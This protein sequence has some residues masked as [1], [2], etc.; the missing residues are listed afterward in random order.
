MHFFRAFNLT[1]KH[2]N[3]DLDE[4]CRSSG[5][6]SKKLVVFCGGFDTNITT[7]ERLIAAMTMEAKRYLM[8]LVIEGEG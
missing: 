5:I 1:A 8:Q 3:I 6:S 4:L 7:V 2:F